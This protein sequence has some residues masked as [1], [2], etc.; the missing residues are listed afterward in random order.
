MTSQKEKYP[1]PSIN[2]AHKQR[3]YNTLCPAD[4]LI[5]TAKYRRRAQSKNLISGEESERIA[6]HG[7][8]RPALWGQVEV[9]KNPK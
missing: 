4:H 6:S 7:N 5:S 3:K 9:S 2:F 1:L 8:R